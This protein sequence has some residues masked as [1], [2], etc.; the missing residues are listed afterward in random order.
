MKKKIYKTKTVV[1]YINSVTGDEFKT[2]KAALKSENRSKGIRSLFKFFIPTPKDKSCKF[3]NGGWCYQR[4]KE[5]FIKFREALVIAIKKYH[6][7]IASQYNEDGG[8]NINHIGASFI[9]GRYLSDSNSEIYKYYCT[10]SNICPVCFREW[11]QQY[12]ATHCDHTAV[13][14]KL[15]GK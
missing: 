5:D 8:F 11:G 7:W 1:R 4:T 15:R 6:K 2:E 14:R 9:I 10:F 3:A 12:H 13:P